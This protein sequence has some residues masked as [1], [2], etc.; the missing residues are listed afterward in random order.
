MPSRSRVQVNPFPRIHA[1]LLATCSLPSC[2]EGYC[3]WLHLSPDVLNLC[4][5]PTYQNTLSHK[6]KNLLMFIISA[7]RIYWLTQKK[8][9]LREREACR[10]LKMHLNQRH[11]SPKTKVLLSFMHPHVFPTTTSKQV[12]NN[13]M[14]N[15]LINEKTY[16]SGLVTATSYPWIFLGWLVFII[17]LLKI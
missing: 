1:V 17:C 10:V 15:K 5:T 14:I 8:T 7:H 6:H 13:L 16:D 11:S 12:W 3:L 2:L 4:L 9:L